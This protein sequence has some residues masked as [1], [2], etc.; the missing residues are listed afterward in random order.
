LTLYYVWVIIVAD[1]TIASATIFFGGN[2][3]VDIEIYKCNQPCFGNVP[4]DKL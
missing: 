4:L 2:H 1:A 3:A